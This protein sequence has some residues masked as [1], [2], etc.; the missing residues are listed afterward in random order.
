MAAAGGAMALAS[1]ACAVAGIP[2]VSGVTA[3]PVQQVAPDQEVVDAQAATPAPTPTSLPADTVAG[4]LAEEAVF[5]NVYERVSPAVVNV[6]VSARDQGGDLVDYGSG[7]GFVIDTEGHIVTNRH[8]IA[9]ADA[10][11][12]TFSDGTVLD[13]GIVGS[14]EFSDLAVLKVDAPDGYSFVPVELGDSDTVQV[15]DVVIAIGNP[16]GLTGSMSVGIV[17]A[18]GRTLPTG[19]A[20][21]GGAFSNPMIIQTDAAINP[22]NSGGPLLDTEGRVIG[23]NAA[24]ESRTGSNTGVGFAIPVNTVRRVTTQIVETGRVEY[25]YLGVSAQSEPSLAEIALELDVPTLDGVLLASVV[26]GGPAD[27]AGLRGGSRQ[28][29]FRGH[30]ILL[31]GDIITAIDGVPVDSFEAMLEYLAANARAGQQV[32]LTINRDGEVMDVPLTLGS[33]PDGGS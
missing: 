21:Q 13:A 24:I 27:Q 16:F 29:I 14:D 10:V 15:G 4:V 8:V 26:D 30:R 2:A 1:L 28:E 9:D 23:V 19:A 5:R 3:A 18:I 11:R 7:S 31:G 20:P 22:G 32:M 33:R 6:E 25:P 12:V 17:S